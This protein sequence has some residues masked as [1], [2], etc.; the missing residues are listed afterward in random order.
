[1]SEKLAVTPKT[2][3]RRIPKRGSYDLE[4][5]HKILDEGFIAHVGFTGAGEQTFVI[6][7][8]YARRGDELLI[9]GSSASRMM[10]ALSEEIEICVTV[11]LR[12]RFLMPRRLRRGWMNHL[13]RGFDA[14]AQ[15]S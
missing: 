4:T 13:A 15:D 9:H 3:L 14:R 5:I 12:K 6:P 2:K 10:R 7:T 1:V 8:G 11:T